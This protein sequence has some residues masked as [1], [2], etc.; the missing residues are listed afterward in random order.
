MAYNAYGAG[1]RESVTIFVGYDIPAAP[2]GVSIRGDR[3]SGEV[4]LT[5]DA[6]DTDPQ[7]QSDKASAISYG[8][9]VPGADGTSVG[10]QG[11]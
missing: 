11:E 4:C 5:W 3:Y 9:C 7:R 1:T 2:S 6:V 10:Y 8:I